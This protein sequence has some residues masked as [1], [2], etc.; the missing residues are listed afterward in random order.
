MPSRAETEGG[1]GATSPGDR[2]AHFARVVLAGSL[3]LPGLGIYALAASEASFWPVAVLLTWYG[4][5]SCLLLELAIRRNL[6]TRGRFAGIVLALAVLHL[7]LLTP[8]IGL[9]LAG[10][11]YESGIQFGYPRPHQ[12]T[13]F[14]AHESLFWTL[15]PG[16]PG[17]NAQ[18][19]RTRMLPRTVDPGLVRVVVLG[20]SVAFQGYP[21]TVETLLNAL[22]SQARSSRRWEVLNFSL[23]GYSSHQGRTLAERHGDAM[24]GDVAVI[25]YGWNDHWLAWGEPDATKTVSVGSSSKPSFVADWAR[26]SRI[27][28]AFRRILGPRRSGPS[29]ELRVP[30]PRYRENL[31]SLGSFWQERGA[32]PLFVTLPTSH[33]RLGCPGISGRQGLRREPR[34]R[35]RAASCL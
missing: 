9:R 17:V 5:L 13:R 19:F 24:A 30:L 33:H 15:A 14:V 4:L 1:S 3:L 22:P 21:E 29:E 6:G 25:S 18:G 8:E 10:F 35:D 11:R 34:K 28:Q 12:F 26:R 20:G 31:A 16:T 7:F 23:P 27:L 2:T 32:R